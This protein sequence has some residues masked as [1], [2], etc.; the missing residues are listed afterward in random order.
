MTTVY[1][2][3]SHIMN[4]DTIICT[5]SFQHLGA[6]NVYA[7]KDLGLS[8]RNS[9]NQQ[10]YKSGVCGDA[11]NPHVVLKTANIYTI[12]DKV[13][14][15]R[16]QCHLEEVFPVMMMDVSTT[17]FLQRIAETAK[18]NCFFCTLILWEINNRLRKYIKLRLISAKAYC[19][20]NFS[21]QLQNMTLM[22]Y[23]TVHLNRQLH[24]WY[25]FFILKCNTLLAHINMQTQQTIIITFAWRTV[26]NFTNF[27]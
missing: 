3:Y 5:F 27:N 18:F 4:I 13:G 26:K 17:Y 20:I 6:W 21:T 15:S 8:W 9:S 1:V 22:Q 16:V 14:S 23:I 12:Q 2:S 7:N 25:K 19:Y 10:H 24:S 11:W